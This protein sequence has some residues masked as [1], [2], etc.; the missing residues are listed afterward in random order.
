MTATKLQNDTNSL[1]VPDYAGPGIGITA[2][3]GLCHQVFGLM[4]PPG[5]YPTLPNDMGDPEE[6]ICDACQDTAEDDRAAIP[7][8]DCPIA[9]FFADPITQ[10]YGLG[11]DWDEWSRI[12][13]CPICE[14]RE[15]QES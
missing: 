3:C 5:Q 6:L 2:E 9:A 4:Y 10:A 1:R 15:S 14:Q 7:D 8:H 12:I 13:R 11:G